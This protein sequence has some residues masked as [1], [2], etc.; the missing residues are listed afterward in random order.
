MLPKQ[1][2]RS[3]LVTHCG[4]IK[5]HIF[6]LCCTAWCEWPRHQYKSKR[7]SWLGGGG[8][9]KEG[10]KCKGGSRDRKEELGEQSREDGKM[11][12]TEGKTLE[13]DE[14]GRGTTVET[15]WRWRREK[16][17]VCVWGRGEYCAVA[18]LQAP[19]FCQ[20]RHLYQLNALLMPRHICC[21][22]LLLKPLLD[23]MKKGTE[24]GAKVSLFCPGSFLMEE[25]K[26]GDF[27][28]RFVLGVLLT[29]NHCFPPRRSSLPSPTPCSTLPSSFLYASYLSS[30]PS[31]QFL[32][33]PNFF[34]LSLPSLSRAPLFYSLTTSLPF[35]VMY[36]SS[37]CPILF[38]TYLSQVQVQCLAFFII[39]SSTYIWE[40]AVAF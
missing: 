16:W 32:Y 34:F 23:D 39:L 2:I 3:C 19:H 12:K 36:P 25:K 14:E 10:W 17:S 40:K 26:E 1:E 9:V 24:M 27:W 15:E 33:A 37:A 38:V 7:G 35:S 13:K 29:L 31:C 28:H 4:L 11:A 21:Y 6:V 5:S 30:C 8:R 18:S 22:K 20:R